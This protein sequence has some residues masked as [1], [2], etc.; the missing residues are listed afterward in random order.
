MQLLQPPVI[1]SNLPQVSAG[2]GHICVLGVG[3]AAGWSVSDSSE[4]VQQWDQE[5][6]AGWR[7]GWLFKGS[8]SAGFR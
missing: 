8:V 6:A 5:A 7:P 2:E 4:L 1:S 3:P